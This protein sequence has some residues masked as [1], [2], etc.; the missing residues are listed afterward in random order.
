M[1]EKQFIW[2]IR[3]Y[4]EDTDSG[5][6]VYHS[7]YLNFMERART[8]WLRSLG[9]GQ[10][11]LLRETGMAF[12]VTKMDI[13]FLAPARLDD[14]LKV[15]VT[16]VKRGR[17]SLHLAQEICREADAK[18]LVRATAKVAMLNKSFKPARMPGNFLVAITNYCEL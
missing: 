13:H 3:V 7:N 18:L 8:E 12:A 16:L 14:A 10:E 9:F 6:V 17:A 11:K 1:L 2:P 5:G 4:Y 15:S